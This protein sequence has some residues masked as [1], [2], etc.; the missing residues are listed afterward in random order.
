VPYVT[1]DK[2]GQIISIQGTPQ[3]A[4]AEWLGPDQFDEVT[5]FLGKN[6]TIENF[7]SVLL[8]SDLELIR[9]L[10]DLIDLLC[11][12]HTIVFTDLPLAT[13]KKLGA[14]KYIR[15][16]MES[17]GNLIGEDEGIF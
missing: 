16:N 1:R 7:Q 10:E 9:A 6:P 14:R 11:E 17:L 5:E 15:R 13:Q 3:A 12:N 8:S 2:K 4:D